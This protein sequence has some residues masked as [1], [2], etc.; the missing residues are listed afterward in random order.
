[1]T[2][3]PAVAVAALNDED[4][5]F[6]EKVFRLSSPTTTSRAAGPTTSSEESL[7][8]TSGQILK[9]AEE[10]ADDAYRIVATRVLVLDSVQQF[11]LLV[12]PA[13]FEFV[14]II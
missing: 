14:R 11:L 8:R 12:L 10:D 6:L 2:T 9:A 4:D 5:N 13:N 7:T 3:T 1:M